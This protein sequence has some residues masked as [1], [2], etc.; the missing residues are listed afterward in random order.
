MQR[1]RKVPAPAKTADADELSPEWIE[2]INRRVD[3]IES[4][5]V[6][7]IPAEEVYAGIERRFGFRL[8]K[9]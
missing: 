6:E 4:G 5:R 7:C 3:D 8:R 9:E 2:E 1:K